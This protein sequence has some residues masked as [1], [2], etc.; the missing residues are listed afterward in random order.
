LGQ[1][2]YGTLAAAWSWTAGG[3]AAGFVPW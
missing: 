2:S 1:A 3:A